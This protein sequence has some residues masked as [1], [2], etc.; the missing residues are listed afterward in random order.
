MPRSST[1]RFTEK[2]QVSVGDDGFL[3]GIVDRWRNSSCASA[4][5]AAQ[6]MA[7][8]AEAMNIGTQPSSEATGAP[9]V[10]DDRAARPREGAPER[11]DFPAIRRE[12][13]APAA[14]PSGQSAATMRALRE[15]MQQ[16]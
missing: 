12:A 1:A 9:P 6:Q 15:R 14:A 2:W 7:M 4:A 5:D 13:P 11:R 8:F 3:E 16:R 10:A